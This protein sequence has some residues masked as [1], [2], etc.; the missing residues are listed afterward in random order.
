M[1]SDCYTLKELVQELRADQKQQTIHTTAILTTLENI[2]N[3]LSKLNSKVA[4]HEK[5]LNS[6]GTFQTKVMTVW[7]VAIF[8]IVTVL[9]KVI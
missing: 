6:L 5:Q 3:H 2:D 1:K 7:G 9:N 4:S 8:I